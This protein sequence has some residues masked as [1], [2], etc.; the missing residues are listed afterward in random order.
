MS[1]TGIVTIGYEG[2]NIDQFISILVENHVGK[3]IDIRKK[4]V[5]RKAGFSKLPLKSALEKAGI[6]YLHL[7]DLGIE[8]AQ[9]QNLTEEGFAKL[10]RRYALELQ[11]KEDLLA[12][13]KSLAQKEKVAMMCFEARETECHR[14]VIAR[15]FREQ[16]VDV[17]V[18]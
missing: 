14:S 7:P 17:V 18:L 8:S 10:F 11:T 2:R 6:L 1:E 16:G 9:R 15:I 3:L 13:I 5:S 4:A 12:T